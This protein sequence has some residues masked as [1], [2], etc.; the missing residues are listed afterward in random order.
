[1]VTLNH[2]KFMAADAA[3]RVVK[4]ET[5]NT[6]GQEVAILVNEQKPSGNYSVLWNAA[7]MS[8]GLYFT[9][10]SECTG[11]DQPFLQMRKMLLTK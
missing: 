9:V 7:R 11:T 3:V 5:N 1:M 8:S 2:Y 6:L 4:M 10:L